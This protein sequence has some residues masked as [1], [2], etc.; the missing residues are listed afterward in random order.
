MSMMGNEL[1]ISFK[2][3]EKGIIKSQVI[4]MGG[5]EFETPYTDIKYD[6]HGNWISRKSSVMGQ[7]VVQNRTKNPQGQ[8]RI[9]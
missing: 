5:Q 2:Y 7:D 6:D 9:R 1:T 8:S 3:D 4:N